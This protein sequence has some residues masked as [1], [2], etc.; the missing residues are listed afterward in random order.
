MNKAITQLTTFRKEVPDKQKIFD[1][2]AY[3]LFFLVICWIVFLTDEYLG[4]DLKSHGMRPRSLEGLQGIITMHFLHADLKHIAQNSMGF[5]VLN[6]FLFYFYRSISL[7]VF[8][9]LFFLTPVLLWFIGR[10]ENHIGASALIYGEFGFL[11]ISGIIRNNPILLRVSLAVFFY[12]GSLVWYLFPINPAISWE[13]HASGFAIGVGAAIYLRK[14]GPQRK[15]YLYETEPE[16]PD[17]DENAYWKIPNTTNVVKPEQ[18]EI[19][20]QQT[21]VTVRYHFKEGDNSKQK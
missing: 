3:S 18:E 14:K 13:G 11:A 17:D 9:L 21:R 20:K 5:L 2:I 19:D 6:S 10:P 8:V 1:A 16:L 7:H 15:K 4:F 12:Y